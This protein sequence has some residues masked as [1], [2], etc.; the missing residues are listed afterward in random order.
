MLILQVKRLK[1]IP[2]PYLPPPIFEQ[3]H[4]FLLALKILHKISCQKCK[5]QGATSSTIEKSNE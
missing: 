3:D 4:W 5:F 1:D 2:Q